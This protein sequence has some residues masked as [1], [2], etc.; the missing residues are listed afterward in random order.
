MQEPMDNITDEKPSANKWPIIAAFV[1][2]VMMLAGSV[3]LSLI[4]I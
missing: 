1:L 2:G 3:G 4:H